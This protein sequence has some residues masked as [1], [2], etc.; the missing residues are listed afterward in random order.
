MCKI[1]VFG[2]TTE[3]RKL[4]E[5]LSAQPVSVTAC[6]ATEYG[7]D[8]LGEAE[9]TV[10]S[11][12]RL[13]KAEIKEMLHASRF[14]LVVDATHP[15]AASITESVSSACAEMGTEYLRLLRD[16]TEVPDDAIFAENTAQA[17][18]YLNGMDGNILLTTGSKELGAYSAVRDFNQRVFVRVLPMAES[19]EL[20]RLAGVKPAHI[21]A[22]QGPFSEEM[23]LAMLKQTNANVLVTKNGGHAGGFAEKV[24]AAKQLGAKLVIIGRP[25]QKAGMDL[26]GVI[27]AL[28]E[29]YKLAPKM[30][31]AVVGIG[32]GNRNAM[33]GE[34][35]E[36]IY[37]ADCLIGAKRM[38]EAVALPGQAVFHAVAPKEIADFIATLPEHRRIA[39]VMSGDVGF[40]SGTKKLLPL[41]EG[42]PVRI[43]PGLNSMVYLCAKSYEDVIPV[44]LHG[45]EHNIVPDV[46][47]HPRI[48]ALVGGEDG[49][50]TLCTKLTEDGLGKV[51]L[52]IGERLSYG[53]EKITKGSAEALCQGSYDSLSVALIEN[54]AADP[55]VTHG[56]PDEAFQR[57]G[58]GPVVPMTK[59]EVRSVCLS[60]LQLTRNAVCWD[61][62]AGT[63]SVAIEMALQ[64]ACGHRAERQCGRTFAVQQRAVRSEQSF[65]CCGDSPRKLRRAADSHPCFY[66]WQQWK[67]KVHS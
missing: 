52:S 34:V 3:G 4:I 24:A 42:Y 11:A 21:I 50:K 18:E 15:Y 38:V 7:E 6:V 62:G 44:S 13:P 29:K 10:V 20:C 51:K 63:G 25:T 16:E 65:R 57:S 56:L 40:F 2:G 12:R 22:M 35:S 32:P 67:Y 37:S 36:A 33:T 39:V 60:K 8:L 27:H 41:L 5:F 14:D 43:L 28:C 23:N 49:M 61:V 53:D 31:I 48:F 45:R 64:A 19:L 54:P 55:I 66:R 1:C 30:E 9:N 26:S 59:S 46:K 58:E 17:I 47:N